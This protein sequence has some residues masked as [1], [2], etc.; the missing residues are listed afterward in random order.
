MF[1][2]C[3]R[4]KQSREQVTHKRKAEKPTGDREAGQRGRSDCRKPHRPALRDQGRGG[5]ATVAGPASPEGSQN[6][7]EPQLPQD[8]ATAGDPPK[9]EGRGVEPRPLPL[10]SLPERLANRLGF[11]FHWLN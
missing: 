8:S 4:G 1:N 9:P 7:P 6:H 3:H 5:V 11:L 10:P 2:N